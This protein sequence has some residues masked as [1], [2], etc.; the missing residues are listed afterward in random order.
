M[1]HGMVSALGEFRKGEKK[2]PSPFTGLRDEF[3][4][5]WCYLKKRLIIFHVPT[6]H[7]PQIPA[8]IAKH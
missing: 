4:L 2:A 1:C 7:I 5:Q 6:V 3:T 8:K